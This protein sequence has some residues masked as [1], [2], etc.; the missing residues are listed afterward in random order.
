MS[1]QPKKPSKPIRK[2]AEKWGVS[3]KTVKRW[4]K[5]G[6]IDPPEL[7]NGRYYISEDNEP[8]RDREK[9]SA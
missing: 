8:R 1:D 5:A 3:V 2:Y 7:I 4:G 9:Q 6:I